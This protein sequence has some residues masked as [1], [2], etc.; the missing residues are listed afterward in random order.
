MGSV[1]IIIRPNEDHYAPNGSSYA[2]QEAS[3]P[4]RLTDRRF[5]DPRS[6]RSHPTLPDRRGTRRTRRPDRPPNPGR[7][8]AAAFR[9]VP[10][11]GHSGGGHRLP[12][13]AGHGPSPATPRGLARRHGRPRP[14]ARRGLDPGADRVPPDRAPRR[15][16]CHPARHGGRARAGEKASRA[17]P[18]RGGSRS[19]LR[20][21]LP[22]TRD[23]G[24]LCQ[25]RCTSTRGSEEG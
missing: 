25:R 24:P 18:D 13:V 5:S 16:A 14:A 2:P 1:A 20:G 10:A 21:V 15:G 11:R 22:G 8:S 6:R 3:E 23:P 9:P 12:L 7:R 4:S 19:R 17:A